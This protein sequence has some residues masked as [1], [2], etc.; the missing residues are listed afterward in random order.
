MTA[1]RE[2][3]EQEFN[4]KQ[5]EIDQLNKTLPPEM[6][7]QQTAMMGQPQAPNAGGQLAN[8]QIDLGGMLS[9]EYVNPATGVKGEMAKGLM[10]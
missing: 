7:G 9:K 2:Q 1:S 4:S 5:V 6:R 8:S 3:L 10:S